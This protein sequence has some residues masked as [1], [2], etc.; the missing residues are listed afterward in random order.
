MMSAALL[1]ACAAPEPVGVNPPSAATAPALM[2][3][4]DLSELAG[5]H[6]PQI[7]A[8][9]GQPDLRRDEPPAEVWQ[10]RNADCV[11]NLFFYQGP[12]GY[13]IVHSE[14]WQRSLAIGGA[15]GRCSDEAAPLRA[16]LIRQSAL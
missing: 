5:L 16:H 2:R 11:V 14:A 4:P 9:L 3:V 6:P 13:R 12:D 7:L 8:M 10:Y 15:L 1:A